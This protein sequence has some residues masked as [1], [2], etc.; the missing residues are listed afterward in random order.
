MLQRLKWLPGGAALAA[1]VVVAACDRAPE[2][3]LPEH[4]AEPAAKPAAPR[5]APP[6]RDDSLDRQGVI[7]ATLRAMTDAAL[8][9]D[10]TEA[11]RALRGRK[12]SV[13]I[14]FGCAGMADPDRSW[15][16]DA[17]REVL[18]VKVRSTLTAEA[19]PKSDLL[20]SEYQGLVGFALARPWL[21][22]A[23]CPVEGYGSATAA[24]PGIV[25]AQLFTK[26]DSRV[27]RPQ[28]DYELTK[29]LEANAQPGDGLDLMLSGR[30]SELADGRPIHCAATAGPPACIVSARID[31]VA[32]ENPA[33]GELLGEWGTGAG[34]SGAN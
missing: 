1:M 20:M 3:K 24:A 12:F 7:L 21:L 32:I 22:S 26:A 28:R 33:S 2:P 30:L 11:Q 9:R 31:R 19:L 6:I 4:R 14:R 5:P 34:V 27:Q 29:P 18:R 17:K 16:Y 23:G 10:D 15:S 8:G 13:R 25:I